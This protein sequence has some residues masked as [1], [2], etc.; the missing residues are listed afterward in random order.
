ME[1]TLAFFAAALPSAVFIGPFA[2]LVAGA[3]A[4]AESLEARVDDNLVIAVVCVVG[5]RLTG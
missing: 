1:G 3:A 2:I 4:L 5:F